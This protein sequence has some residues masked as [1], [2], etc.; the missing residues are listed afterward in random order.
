MA[1]QHPWHL[2]SNEHNRLRYLA[3]SCFLSDIETTLVLVALVVAAVAEVALVEALRLG[4][5]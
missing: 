3:K 2:V 4:M 5:L 1:F